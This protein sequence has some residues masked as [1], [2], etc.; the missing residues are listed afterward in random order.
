MASA[1][2]LGAQLTIWSRA[3]VSLQCNMLISALQY[4]TLFSVVSSQNELGKYTDCMPTVQLILVRILLLI[5]MLASVL[6]LIVLS[7]MYPT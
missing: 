7:A 3:A 1:T 4:A 5:L 6:I 2:S